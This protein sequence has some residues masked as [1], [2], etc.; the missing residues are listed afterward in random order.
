[1][2]NIKAATQNLR[3]L[4]AQVSEPWWRVLTRTILGAFVVAAGVAVVVF[5]H[6][7]WWV[8]VIGAVWGAHTWKG[9]LVTEF[10]KTVPKLVAAAIVDIVRALKGEPPPGPPAVP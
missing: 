9:E 6:A 5:F 8:A 2:S 3:A 10:L 1:V 4:K 7:P